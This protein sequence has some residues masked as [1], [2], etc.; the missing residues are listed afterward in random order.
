M[1]IRLIQSEIDLADKFVEMG[2]NE[3][4]WNSENI[5]EFMQDLRAPVECLHSRIVQIQSN[6]NEIKDVMTSWAKAPLFIRKDGK[7]EATLCIE[8][9]KDRVKKRYA[10]IRDVAVRVHE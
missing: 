5:T 10:E 2:C 3:L 4:N 1:E 6:L 9:R 7:K 8:E